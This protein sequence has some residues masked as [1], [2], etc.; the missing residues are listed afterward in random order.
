MPQIQMTPEYLTGM[1]SIIEQKVT[2]LLAFRART[3]EQTTVTQTQNFTWRL[4]VTGGVE[5]PKWI[6]IG[7]QT[8]KVDHDRSRTVTNWDRGT[9]RI[10][11]SADDLS[12][13]LGSPCLQHDIA[14]TTGT[15]K[16]DHGDNGRPT[17]QP[18]ASI[19][20]SKR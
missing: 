7:F 15:V 8:D 10:L 9:K 11:A 1:R 5:K 18:L 13:R 3:C 4:S 2:L 14:M 17:L 19:M 16:L 12:R 6:I 20:C